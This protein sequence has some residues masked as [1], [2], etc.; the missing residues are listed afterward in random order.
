MAKRLT[1]A[2]IDT[3]LTLHKAG[4]SNREIAALLGVNRETIGKHLGRVKAQNQ[5]NA[6]TGKPTDDPNGYQPNAPTGNE[7]GND[8]A[9]AATESQPNAPTDSASSPANGPPSECEAFREE[10][11]AKIEQGLEAVRIH[12]D[13]VVDHRDSAPSYYSVRRFIARLRQKVPLPFRRMETGPA[14]EAQVDFGSGAA[15]RTSD[16]KVRRPWIFRIVLSYS[17]KAYSEAVWRQTSEAFIGCL[18]NAFRHFGGVPK[19]LVIDNL[20]A[21]VARGDWYDPE[22]HPKLQSFARHYGT[23]FLPTKPY[24][25][26]HKGKIESG[27]KY[28]KR[29]AL[30]GRVFQS[31]AEENEFLFNWETQVA[32]QRIHGTT[33]QQV[34]KLFEQAERRELLPL[35]RERFP[36]FHEAHRA[37]HRDG[38]LEVDKAYYSVPPEY[39]G[40]R[41]WVRWDSRLVRI[42]NYRWEQL[43]VHAKAEPGRFRTAPEHIPQE[44]VSAVER[45]TDALLRQIAAIGPNTR[46]WAEATTQARGVEAVRVLV[47]LKA[48]AGKHRTE[49]LEE[50]C[51]VALSHGAYRL[52]TVRQL[53]QR[54]GQAQQQFEFLEEHPIIR[55]LSDYSL[56][57]LLQFRRERKHD[58]RQI[59]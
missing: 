39:V 30:R 23:V 47:G 8:R 15:V 36:F 16:G 46:Q 55:P 42:F 2:E 52:R 38:Y 22:V 41:L 58:E 21:A 59:G 18:E 19:R 48:L 7:A 24:M 14:E 3:I 49:A 1:M 32:D 50:A 26:R 27:V 6:P 10:I 31:L 33:K 20:K 40:H 45:G 11:V 29:N 43:V 35:P 34:E 44:K 9:D 4:H 37:V 13:L 12:Q 17:R 54:K 25:P 57:S 53:L 5:P 56:T 51:R 28:V